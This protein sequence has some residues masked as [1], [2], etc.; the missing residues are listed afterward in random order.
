M[1]SRGKAETEKLRT[2]LQDQLNRL[3]AQLQDL[4]EMKS[5]MD[6]S[7]YDEMKADTIQQLKEFEV[8]LQKMIAGDMTLVDEFSSV[9]LAIQA[10]VR[11]AF[12]T[13]EV[14]KLFAKK[15]PGQ[16]RERLAVLQRDVRLQKIS[17]ATYTQ[18]AVEI[19]IALKKLGE[20]LSPEEAQF[21]QANMSK[22]MVDFENSSGQIGSASEASILTTA[23]Q[24]V[25]K[26]SGN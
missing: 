6:A 18:Q 7:E 11:E 17:E 25:Q 14:I 9:Q 10:T 12:K 26:A 5:E 24:G 23:A 2:N 20:Q 15:Q 8:K 4:E 1:S 3:L 21:L 22:N 16:L 19:I 13:P